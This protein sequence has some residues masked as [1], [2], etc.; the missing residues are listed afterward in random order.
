M[1]TLSKYTENYKTSSRVHGSLHR[2]MAA[3]LVQIHINL[4]MIT[5]QTYSTF[6]TKNPNTFHGKEISHA[7]PPT[8]HRALSWKWLRIQPVQWHADFSHPD[9][10]VSTSLGKADMNLYELNSAI[11]SNCC[12]SQLDSLRHTCTSRQEIAPSS[13]SH[14]LIPKMRSCEQRW[15]K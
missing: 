4:W 1:W 14:Q 3:N 7:A 11:T 12:P 6:C 15:L 5:R 13:Q 2:N 10:I 8:H 9:E